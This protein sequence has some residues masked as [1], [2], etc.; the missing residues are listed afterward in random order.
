M[1]ILST[2][3][4]TFVLFTEIPL[5]VSNITYSKTNDSISPNWQHE[6]VCF[7]PITYEIKVQNDIKTVSTLNTTNPK[8]T[9]KE[10][11][12]NTKYTIAIRAVYG[13][14]KSRPNEMMITTLGWY[15]C[16]YKFYCSM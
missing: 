13:I 9:I 2:R 4:C 14:L 7:D 6:D 10:L 1:F 12:P 3:K 5:S 15:A 11:V 8:I 16:I